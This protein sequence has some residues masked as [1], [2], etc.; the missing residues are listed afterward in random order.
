MNTVGYRPNSINTVGC[1]PS[2][3][4]WLCKQWPLQAVNSNRGMMLCSPSDSNIMQKPKHYAMKTYGR[5][6]FYIHVFLTLAL[7]GGQWSASHPWQF[8]TRERAPVI[9][10]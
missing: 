7:I 10:A 3:K 8:T 1:R 5:G 9:L 4:K 6:M 2:T